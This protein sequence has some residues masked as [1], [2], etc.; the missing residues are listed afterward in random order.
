MQQK[1]RNLNMLETMERMMN[2]VQ[3]S[4]PLE[5]NA[6]FCRNCGLPV[7]TSQA[8]R[9]LVSPPEEQVTENTL[10][11]SSLV[12]E[13]K[14]HSS[15]P[16]A[17]YQR[18]PYYQQAQAS[19]KEASTLPEVHAS[20]PTF[21]Q[22]SFPVQS[23]LDFY[24]PREAN[25]GT[26]SA[27]VNA[28][29]RRNRA[30][31]VLGCLGMLL[32]LILVLGAAW[33]F[34]LRPYIHDVAV[35]QMDNA[36]TNVVNQLPAVGLPIP[37]GTTLPLSEGTVNTVLANNVADSDPVQGTNMQITS[38]QILLAFKLYGQDSTITSI[39]QMQNGKLVATNVATSGVIGL[40]LSPKDITA[41]LN[42]HFEDAQ[43]RI[44]H[45]ITNVRLLDHEIDVTVG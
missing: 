10:S 16:Q 33:V 2:C 45:R 42:K 44:N 29:R 7:A 18:Q 31:C 39:P 3:C 1:S 9:V 8:Q 21:Y 15:S 14:A 34:A 5:A 25:R 23:P 32:V 27:V 13:L 36:M 4:V 41:L 30:G 19:P 6:R 38:N 24:Q 22:A 35:T 12:E 20:V 37:P 40:V 11:I 28:P 26:R 17:F 43:T